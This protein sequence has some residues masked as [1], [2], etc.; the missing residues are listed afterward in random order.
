[1]VSQNLYWCPT[2]APGTNPYQWPL[3]S[4]LEGVGVRLPVVEVADDG[5]GRG[6][7]GPHPEADAAVGDDGAHAGQVV[8]GH[9]DP[10]SWLNIRGYH[11]FRPFASA[12]P[13]HRI[14]CCCNNDECV[15]MRRAWK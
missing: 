6:V 1:M 11:C 13:T 2:R 3:P 4:A 7:G 10:S 15:A 14:E 9:G 8:V 5:D 12:G